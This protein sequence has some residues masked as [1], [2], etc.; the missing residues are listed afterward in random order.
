MVTKLII[1][2]VIVLAV[3]AVAQLMRVYELSS[4]LRNKQESEISQRDNNFNAKMM[5]LFMI[6]LFGGFI[7]L[8][9]HYGWVGRGHS[10][11]VHGHELD[12]LLNLNLISSA[13]TKS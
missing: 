2:G 10:A 6:G 12:W 8:I 9:I 7:W 5:L 1:L 4:K 11:S 13:R 3:I